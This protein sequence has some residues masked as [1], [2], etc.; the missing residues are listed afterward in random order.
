[1][2]GIT[3]GNGFIGSHLAKRIEYSLLFNGDL[4]DRKLVRQFVRECD[5]IYH[6]AGKN[7]GTGILENNL[8]ATANLVL[9]TKLEGVNPLII[10]ASTTK[11]ETDPNSE[12]GLVKRAEEALIKGASKWCIYR[13]PNVYGEGC[14]PYYN[15][16]VATFCDQI[17]NGKQIDISKDSREFI[18]IDDLVSE[19]LDYKLY[20]I[21]R[22]QGEE[23]TIRQV[24]EYLTIKLGQHEKLMRCYDWAIANNKRSI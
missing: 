13:I 15:S 23:M 3:G 12:Y 2:V 5:V 19:L 16:V 20:K 4:K 9:A 11:V 24:Y 10:F 1:M 22:P 21:I 18:Y 17:I 8:I 6:I 7:R 14:K